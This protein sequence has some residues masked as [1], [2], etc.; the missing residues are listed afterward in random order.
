MR[1]FSY[2]VRQNNNEKQSIESFYDKETINKFILYKDDKSQ[3]DKFLVFDS[4]A[5][6]W[7]YYLN[8]DD[9]KYFEIILDSTHGK[10]NLQR[11]KFDIDAEITKLN[12]INILELGELYNIH[13]EQ[14]K[15]A[16]V[17]KMYTILDIILLQIVETFNL[18]YNEKITKKDI[19]IFDSSGK[20]NGEYK[21]S[22]HVLI[23]PFGV[24]YAE[25]SK[26]FTNHVT[27]NLNPNIATLIDNTV[28]SRN[29]QFRM[30]LSTKNDS[31]RVKHMNYELSKYMGTFDEEIDI[32]NPYFRDIVSVRSEIVT[33]L[34]SI[35]TN[36]TQ[37]ITTGITNDHITQAIKMF[38]DSI[39]SEFFYVSTTRDNIINCRRK[40]SSMCPVH[41]KMHDSENM[42]LIIRTINSK[43]LV[44]YNCLRARVENQNFVTLGE[45]IDPNA[46]VVTEKIKQD[47]FIVRHI[48]DIND[49]KIDVGKSLRTKFETLPIT[50]RLTYNEPTIRPYELHNSLVVQCQMKMG[51]TKALRNFLDTYFVDGVISKYTIRFISSRLTFTNSVVKDFNEFELYNDILDLDIIAHKYPKVIIQVE[52]LHRLSC[53]DKVDLLIIDEVESVLEQFN[54]PNHKNL[55]EAFAIF[56]KLMRDTEHV[57]LM[58]ANISDRTYNILS[59]F[60]PNYQIY[61][62]HNTFLRASDDIYYF[63]NNTTSWYN[64]L[65]LALLQNKRIV[66]PTNSLKHATQCNKLIEDFCKLN[67]L[68]HRIQMYTSETSQATKQRHFKD[69]KTHWKNYDILI[70]TPTLSAGVSFEDEHFD[71]LFG[72]FIDSSCNV[73]ICRQMLGR[74]RNLKYKEHYICL[75]GRQKF[76]PTNIDHMKSLLLS[77]KMQLLNTQIQ[78]P[79]YYTYDTNGEKMYYEQPYAKLW[80]ENTRMNNISQ[81]NFVFRFIDEV[82]YSGADINV[83]QHEDIDGNKYG[84]MASH[85]DEASY[86]ILVEKSK[87]IAEAAEITKE[88][89]DEIDIKRKLQQ[90]I[91]PEEQYSAEKYWFIDTFKWSSET[92]ITPEFVQEYNRPDVKTVFRN[93]SK[94]SQ[95][96]T[97]EKSLEIIKEKESKLHKKIEE[98][99]GAV[100]QELQHNRT[101]SYTHHSLAYKILRDSG[102][103][104]GTLNYVH[105]IDLYNRYTVLGGYLDREKNLIQ[106]LVEKK[107]DVKTRYVELSKIAENENIIDPQVRKRLEEYIKYILS[108]I[109]PFLSRMYGIHI[110]KG[111]DKGKYNRDGFYYLEETEIGKKFIKTSHK[112]PIV[113]ISQKEKEIKDYREIDR[114]YYNYIYSS[115]YK[116]THPYDDEY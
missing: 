11:I 63:T 13:K 115:D 46:E 77:K 48:Q 87:N 61:F 99:D 49:G 104:I 71:M 97:F 64:K 86:E 16:T 25:E 44:V 43:L 114:F 40:K 3:L 59:H 72:Y 89:N 55:N 56:E 98:D 90:E 62:H 41:D 28:N 103:M 65:E 5:E 105:Y 22:Y 31:S 102:M 75:K 8:Q 4:S 107:Y 66:I 30:Y 10:N 70:Y 113:L 50:N 7:D 24:L 1:S 108:I 58:D 83:L 101:I 54:S 6:M 35:L 38:D 112:P 76:L 2:L 100:M 36:T 32:S 67:K 92:S 68:N 73:E 96:S 47:D 18:T 23:C 57:I 26:I 91:T 51:K 21:F 33:Q 94:I 37:Y 111:N 19:I 82:K 29:H 34:P 12:N 93:L 95:D 42:S 109:N 52:S 84:Y 80:F 78:P 14:I 39:Y 110:I 17:A 20:K 9:K 74:V 15:D 27:T 116:M 53:Y 79:V 60:R 45:I 106:E 81:N 88:Q 69:V 85:I